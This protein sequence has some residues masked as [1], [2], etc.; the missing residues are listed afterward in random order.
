MLPPYI[1]FGSPED[2]R[3]NCLTLVPKPP[4][5]LDFI[6]Y[7]LDATKKLRYKLK[8]E[9]VHEVDSHRDFVMEFCLGNGQMSIVELAARNSG[10]TK[11]RFMSSARLRKPGTDVDDD[12]FYGTKDFAIGNYKGSKYPT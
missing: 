6:T 5:T 8:M 2:T 1:G 10:F 7:V 9:P 11:G 3:Q 4:R 12:A